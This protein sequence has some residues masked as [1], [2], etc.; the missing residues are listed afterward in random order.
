VRRREFI[1]LLGG[2]GAAWPLAARAQQSALPV[3]GFLSSSL[4]EPYVPMVAA[5]RQGLQEVGYFEGQNVA[6]EFRWAENDWSRLPT[7]VADLINRHAAAIVT[8]GGYTPTQAAKQATTNIPI[9]FVGAGDPVAAGLVASINRPGGNITGINFFTVELE[10][11]RLE[12]LREIVPK[13]KMI[14]V[15]V[16]PDSPVVQPALNE[17]E[18]AIRAGRQQPLVAKAITTADIETA[19]AT[20]FRERADALHIISDPQ[21]TSRRD[22]VVALAA[23]HAIPTTYSLREFP[24][25]GGLISYGASITDAYRQAGLYIGRILKGTKP[26]ELPVMQPTK[27]ELV[28]NLNTAKALGLEI[29]PKVLAIADEVIE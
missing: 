10:M 25:V 3:I 5:F 2:A 1:T 24:A 7:L 29:P 14:A 9:V 4:A 26:T 27:F 13:A 22:Q 20:F 12:L 16:N 15:L 19:F 11:K 21:F 28:I 17:L 18:R 8:S 6:I 23:R